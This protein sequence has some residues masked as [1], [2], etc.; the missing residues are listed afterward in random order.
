M[1][2]HPDKHIRA[3]IDY[4]IENGWVLKKS[5]PRAHVWGTLF[6]PEHSREGCIRAVYCTPRV[7]EAHARD[8]RRAVNRCPHNA[9]E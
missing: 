3:A 2:D 5:G 4:A 9:E 1:N 8:I 7:P 6:C